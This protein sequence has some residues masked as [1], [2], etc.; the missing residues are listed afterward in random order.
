MVLYV[1]EEEPL[2]PHSS[3]WNE[4]SVYITPHIS[5][6]YASRYTK[7][8]FAKL[9]ETNLKNLVEHKPFKNQVNRPGFN[10]GEFGKLDTR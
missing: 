3:L 1:F 6:G 4:K 7:D 8:L 2:P 5:G 9:V 10:E